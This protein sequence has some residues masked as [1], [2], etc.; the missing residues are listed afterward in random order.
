MP[1]IAMCENGFC[2][3]RGDCHR[4]TAQPS[5]MRQSYG[6]FTHDSRG[7][8]DHYWPTGTWTSDRAQRPTSDTKAPDTGVNAPEKTRA[9]FEEID[10]LAARLMQADRL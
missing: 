2:P 3:S 10:A 7:H 9:A 8:C 5:D 6:L 1:D 4:Y